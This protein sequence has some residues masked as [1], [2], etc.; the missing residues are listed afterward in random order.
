MA[1]SSETIRDVTYAP[2]ARPLYLYLKRESLERPEVA[3]FLRF[4]FADAGG[5]VEDAGLV[6]F[7]DDAY[8]ANQAELDAAIAGTSE[9]DGPDPAGTPAS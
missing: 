1:A 8:A 3:E 9:P 6:P 7:E 4:F 2:L 5:F